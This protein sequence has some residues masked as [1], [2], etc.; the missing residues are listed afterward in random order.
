MELKEAIDKLK[1]IR[2][3]NISWFLKT[4]EKNCEKIYLK[5]IEAIET[6]LKALENSIPKKKIEEVIKEVDKKFAERTYY[7]GWGIIKDFKELLEEKQMS[8]ADE[9]FEDLGYKRKIYKLEDELFEVRYNSHGKEI[10]FDKLRE[11]FGS[12]SGIGVKE[13]QA[14]NEKCKE[15][16][17]LK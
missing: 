4:N 13:L 8:K 5:D 14:I 16:G 2:E 7:N 10:W 17:W 9:M 1:E 6:V 15:L 3:C 12:L 11:E